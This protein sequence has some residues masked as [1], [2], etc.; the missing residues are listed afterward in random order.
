MDPL[1]ACALP[2]AALCLVG[3]A[4]SHIVPV[5]EEENVQYVLDLYKPLVTNWISRLKLEPLKFPKR[6]EEKRYLMYH[7]TGYRIQYAMSVK[8]LTVHQVNPRNV[9]ILLSVD[10]RDFTFFIGIK[11]MLCILFPKLRHYKCAHV[12]N[13][14]NIKVKN[15][16]ISLIATWKS[17]ESGET[18]PLKQSDT[19][20]EFKHKGTE[21]N[22][23]PLLGYIPSENYTDFKDHIRRLIDPPAKQTWPLFK[24]N[25]MGW[26]KHGI[27]NQFDSKI[28]PHITSAFNTII[29]KASKA[30]NMSRE[31]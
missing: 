25:I 3:I 4:T 6:G 27:K 13:S 24:S 16:A 8:N 18:P 11:A 2:L 5:I 22:R 20:V 10:F 31:P 15:A 19:K 30:V 9:S 12:D 17:A 21:L 26:L 7:F 14:Q 1:R 29:L 23:G 28:R